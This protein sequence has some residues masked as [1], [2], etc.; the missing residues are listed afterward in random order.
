VGR[1][2]TRRKH[3]KTPQA[4]GAETKA[5]ERRIDELER[6]KR[7][8]ESR[9]ATALAAGDRRAGQRAS[10]RLRRLQAELDALYEKWTAPGPGD[11]R[12]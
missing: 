10:K 3:R 6:T 12:A 5:L 2:S 11:A 4:P 8:L 1:I 9:I 7:E